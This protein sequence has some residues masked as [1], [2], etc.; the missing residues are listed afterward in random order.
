MDDLLIAASILYVSE[1]R[2]GL[3]ATE[4]AVLRWR[5]C[6][7][8]VALKTHLECVTNQVRGTQDEVYRAHMLNCLE[9][10]RGNVSAAARLSG[11]SRSGFYRAGK[12]LG[13]L[14]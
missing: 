2:K 1:L 7:E 13:I 8:A 10:A 9:E 5:A 11:M 14:K 3:T 12:R 6:D 4:R